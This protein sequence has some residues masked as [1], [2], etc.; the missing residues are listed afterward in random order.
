MVSIDRL[1]A[2]R[3]GRNRSSNRPKTPKLSHYPPTWWVSPEGQI[4]R[5]I[6]FL[7]LYGDGQGFLATDIPPIPDFIPQTPSEVLLLTVILPDKDGVAGTQLTHDAWWNF[8]RLPDGFAKRRPQ[9][10]WGTISEPLFMKLV[11]GIRHLPGIKWVAFDPVA[12]R[13]KSPGWL[14]QKPARVVTLAHAE[15]LMAMALFPDWIATW[16]GQDSPYP[17]MSGYMFND[18]VS[19]GNVPGVWGDYRSRVI[20]LDIIPDYTIP[21]GSSSPAVRSASESA[22]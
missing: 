2:L 15:V 6:T 16:N 1:P 13:D 5:I 20:R 4:D 14:R 18:G 7:G 10:R 9:I 8:V 3:L 17:V 21:R 19:W 11:P 12:H 22:R